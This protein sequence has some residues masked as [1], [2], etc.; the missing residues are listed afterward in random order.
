[1]K[2]LYFLLGFLISALITCLLSISVLDD[3]IQSKAEYGYFEGQKDAINKDIR[4]KLNS[5]SIYVWIKSPWDDN[6]KPI[7]NPDRLDTTN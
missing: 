4:I 7:F 2:I 6:R 5:D 1:M 3:Y